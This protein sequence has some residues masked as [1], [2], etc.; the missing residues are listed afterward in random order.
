[1]MHIFFKSSEKLIMKR[2]F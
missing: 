2:I 1:V